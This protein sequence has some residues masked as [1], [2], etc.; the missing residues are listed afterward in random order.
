MGNPEQG[1]LAGCHLLQQTGDVR[2]GLE[3]ILDQQPLK[4]SA[5]PWLHC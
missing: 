4:A 3:E 2:E 5:N 1:T